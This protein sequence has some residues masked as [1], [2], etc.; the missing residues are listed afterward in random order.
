MFRVSVVVKKS[1]KCKNR[2][3]VTSRQPHDRP[4]SEL[5][6]RPV[7]VSSCRVPYRSRSSYHCVA[8]APVPPS[9]PGPNPDPGPPAAPVRA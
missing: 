8:P 5:A 7:G 6:V 1:A 4:V 3:R 2:C 9:S